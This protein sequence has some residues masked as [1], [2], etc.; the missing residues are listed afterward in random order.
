MYMQNYLRSLG[1]LEEE[2]VEELSSY[3]SAQTIQKR[4]F[5]IREGMVCR[6]VAYLKKG[7]LRSFYTDENGNDITYCITFRDKFMTAYSSFITGQPTQENIQAVTDAEMIIFQK[8]T[9][10]KLSEKSV[11]WI[12]LQKHFAE[13][14]YISMEKRMFSYQREDAKQRYQQLMEE[15]P[16]FIQEV[17][18]QYIASYLGV[19]QRHLSRIRKELS[20]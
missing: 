6:Q 19:S 7:I 9:F 18:L 3:G 8:E 13:Q 1:I 2:E 12:K 15:Y 4:D 11:N 16:E 10:D 14:E 20:N 5:F 17:P